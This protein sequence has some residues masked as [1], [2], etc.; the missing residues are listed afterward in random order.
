MA[1]DTGL[2]HLSI[3]NIFI[4]DPFSLEER[5]RANVPTPHVF[6]NIKQKIAQVIFTDVKVSTV[7][8]FC[9]FTEY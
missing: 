5:K 3:F 6:I 4:T 7:T 9:Y 2:L 1:L 8:G